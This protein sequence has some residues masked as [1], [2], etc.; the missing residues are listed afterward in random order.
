MEWLNYHHLFY[1]W[2]IA[3]EGSVTAAGKALNLSQPALSGQIRQLEEA[4][5]EKLFERQGRGL[6]LS[7]A[8][9]VAFRYADEIFTLGREFQSELKGR[10]TGRPLRLVI[11]VSDLLPKLLVHRLLR[12]ALSL[13]EPLRLT[14]REGALTGMTQALFSHELDLVFSETPWPARAGGRAYNHL[15]GEWEL[16]IVGTPELRK[17]HPGR[18]PRCLDGAPMLLPSE[19]SFLRLAMDR[20]FEQ[21]GIRPVVAG[22]FDDSALLKT[23]GGEGEGFFA[24]PEAILRE[25]N[26]SFGTR[27]VGAMT[28]VQTRIYAISTDRRLVHPAVLAILQAAKELPS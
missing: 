9:R 11:G 15:L 16:R 1:F 24:V 6:V 12:P 28:G 19:G 8:G 4:L 26:R 27:S 23:F 17:R 2:T 25:V 18:F 20:W 22:D 7:E 3:R 5:G 13:P 10:P 14:C 21:Q